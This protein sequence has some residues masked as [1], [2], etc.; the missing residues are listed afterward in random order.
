MMT[1]LC[2][3]IAFPF[4]YTVLLITVPHLQNCHHHPLRFRH[5]TIHHHLHHLHLQCHCH[6]DCF[7]NLTT[8]MYL[9]RHINLRTYL[10]YYFYCGCS[11]RCNANK[12]AHWHLSPILVLHWAGQL[13]YLTCVEVVWTAKTE[14]SWV[15]HEPTMMSTM[16][17]YWHNC[18]SQYELQLITVSLIC[19]CMQ[20]FTIAC[21]VYC[22]F[23]LA[24]T[25]IL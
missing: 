9:I 11:C 4:Q 19:V 21:G 15:C 5:P 16:F 14:V 22:C 2:H 17:H 24:T 12:I 25:R 7:I 13:D 3:Q 8:T 10:L 1:H 20:F 18:H 23:S 6:Y